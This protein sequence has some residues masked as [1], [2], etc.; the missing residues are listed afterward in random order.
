MI[1]YLAKLTGWLGQH[2]FYIVL[3][4]LLLGFLIPLPDSPPLRI[5]AVGAFAYMTF[6]TALGTSLKEFLLV[7]KKPVIPLW[8]L[9]L[10]HVI[11]PLIAYIIGL[12]LFSG[13]H[14]SQLGYLVATS[15]PIG[16]T[17]VIWTA[18]A[19]GSVTIA[20]VA[21]TLDTLIVPV[22]LPFFFK[23]VIGQTLQIDYIQMM[24][25]LLAMITL[26][27]M[28]GMLLHDYGKKDVLP[29]SLKILGN[30]LAKIAF[31]IVIFINAAIVGPDISW[32]LSTL[33]IVLV[34]MFLVAAG[35][36]LGYLGSFVFKTRSKEITLAMIYCVGLRNASFGVVLALT[37]FPHAVAVPVTMT[38]LYQQPFA[39]IIPYFFRHKVHDNY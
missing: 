5:A 37:F 2:M 4:G 26:P 1:T 16:V 32:D 38:I 15:T 7:L 12:F 10:I 22:M 17:S 8:I 25:Q 14:Y 34:T 36:F 39:A 3:S 29:G 23:I 9:V 35:Y 21:V 31:F 11:T 19:G 13:D 30:F 20:L 6:V 33:K 18:I 24:V 28:A 27:S